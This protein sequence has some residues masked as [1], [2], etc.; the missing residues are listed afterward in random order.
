M[1]I[2]GASELPLEAIVIQRERRARR[3]LKLDEGLVESVRQHGV[4]EPLVVRRAPDGGIVLMAGERRLEAARA[5]G[6]AAVPVVYFE[7]LDP[8]VARVVELE[9]N[10]KRRDMEW[11]DL[12]QCYAEI[13]ALYLARDPDWT[14]SETA[15]HLAINQGLLSE[16]LRVHAY[17]NEENPRVLASETLREAYNV[18][19]RRLEREAGDALEELLDAGSSVIPAEPGSAAAVPLPS[20][21]G[22]EPGVAPAPVVRMILPVERA[23]QQADFLQWAPA[24]A[25]KKFNFIHCD[26]PYGVGFASGPQGAG[27]EPGVIYDDSADTYWQLVGCLC[28]NLNRLMAISGHLVFWLDSRVE[29]LHRTLGEFAKHAPSLQFYSRPLIWQKS[30]QAGVASDPRR[31]PRHTYETAL[32]A[33]RGR[34]PILKVVN[35]AYSAPTDKRL[36]ISTKPEPMLRHFFQMIVDENTWMLDPTA[37]SAAALRA[38][39]SLGGRGLC[40]ELEQGSVEIARRALKTFRLKG[41]GAEAISG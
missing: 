33:T 5:V 10:V 16:H 32:F 38:T 17:M 14:I 41:A 2:T 39:E 26:F 13:H 9:E 4:I 25:G 22:P 31:F 28:A 8:I 34:R 1:A 18:V 19:N 37:G 11:R 12:T 30:D 40:L 3:E 36:H 29:T 20:G 15:H 23:V 27:S 6:L 35:D 7:T 24:Y 21:P